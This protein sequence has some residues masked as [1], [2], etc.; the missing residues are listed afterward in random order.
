MAKLEELK[1]SVDS[2]RS[3]VY[4]T[5]DADEVKHLMEQ[6][7]KHTIAAW[8]VVDTGNYTVLLANRAR[9]QDKEEHNASMTKLIKTLASKHKMGAALDREI[10]KANEDVISTFESP[11]EQ[12][13]ATKKLIEVNIA[14]LAK[15]LPGQLV[16]WTVQTKAGPKERAGLYVRHSPEIMYAKNVIGKDMEKSWRLS[17]MENLQAPVTA[18]GAASE[19]SGTVDTSESTP[20]LL[21]VLRAK[22]HHIDEDKLKSISSLSEGALNAFAAAHFIDFGNNKKLSYA[23]VVEDDDAM[24]AYKA[25]GSPDSLFNAWLRRVDELLQVLPADDGVERPYVMAGANGS[26]ATPI[27]SISDI[28]AFLRRQ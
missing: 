11:D 21:A 12:E 17:I 15:C 8:Q 16:K 25:C 13:M 24:Q 1:A 18:S 7:E 4:R 20:N 27:Q 14:L 23:N 22:R 3:K 2:L 19:A 6:I 26:R 28:N 10:A 9:L 5:T